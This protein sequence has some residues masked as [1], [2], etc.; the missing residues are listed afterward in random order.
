MIIFPK[1]KVNIGLRIIEKRSDGYHNL[2]SL[3]LDCDTPSDI[4][5]IVESDELSFSI[6]GSELDCKPQDNIC[7]KAYN[8]LNK[9]FNLPGAEIHLNKAIP[10]GAGLG[11]GSSDGACTLIL[12]NRL[13]S[14]GL[15][16]YKLAGYAAVLG[17]DCPFF[18]YAHNEKGRERNPM[19]VKGRGDILEDVH[20]PHL[21]G[22]SVRIV[23]P[24][25]FI[26]TARAY[27]G[28]TPKQ[29]KL[30]IE[31]ILSM[32]VEIWRD[33]LENDFEQ[34][35]FREYP[36]LAQYKEELYQS[37]A[38]YASMSGSGSSLFGLFKLK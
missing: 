27:S 32:P 25:V 24:P 7:I 33:Y 38:V 29:P 17:S 5:E 28:I 13:Y 23:T 21:E 15:D 2:E 12:L 9:E 1:C 14:L 18:I 26:S 37:G 6:Y 10:S 4:L 20:I 8:L 36:L 16:T 19:I 3:F 34:D 11:G 31:K 30:S 35:I 22:Y